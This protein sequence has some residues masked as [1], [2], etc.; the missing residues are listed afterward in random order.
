MIIFTE[1]DGNSV[2]ALLIIKCGNSAALLSHIS[3]QV[4]NVAAVVEHEHLQLLEYSSVVEFKL[5]WRSFHKQN[6]LNQL[7]QPQLG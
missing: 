5:C 2:Y 7:Y 6:E 4:T 1:L 3:A